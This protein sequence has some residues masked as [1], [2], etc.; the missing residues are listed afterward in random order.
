MILNHDLA[1]KLISLVLLNIGS[2]D[3]K[4]QFQN[5]G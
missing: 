4:K 5:D 1:L 3:N 2:V